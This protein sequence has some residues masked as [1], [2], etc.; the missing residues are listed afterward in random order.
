MIQRE[1]GEAGAVLA[2]EFEGREASRSVGLSAWRVQRFCPKETGQ[3][4]IG[5]DLFL[6]EQP[7]LVHTLRDRVE[8]LVAPY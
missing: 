1:T 5:R 2:S 8:A 7:A 3:S 4:L 6:E